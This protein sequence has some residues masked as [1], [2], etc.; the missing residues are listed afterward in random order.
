[1]RRVERSRKSMGHG[2]VDARHDTLIH[3]PSTFK[4]ING[5]E[6]IYIIGIIYNLF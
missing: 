6:Y 3:V 1:M 5:N 2:N 4:Q